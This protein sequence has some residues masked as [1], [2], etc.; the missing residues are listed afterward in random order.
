[1]RSR[2]GEGEKRKKRRLLA[3]PLLPLPLFFSS[4]KIFF[5]AHPFTKR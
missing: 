2:R 1:M 5:N 3:S 4:Y